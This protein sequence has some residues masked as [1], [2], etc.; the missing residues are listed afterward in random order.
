M[1]VGGIGAGFVS[2]D[3][4]GF[5][6]EG[7]VDGVLGEVDEERAVAGGFDEA[8]GVGG[9]PFGE[10]FAVGSVFEGRVAI[11]SEPFFGL[12]AVVAADVEGE[13]VG[14][15]GGVAEVPFADGGG[16][17]VLGFE[18]F[19]ESGEGFGEFLAPVGR[20]EFGGGALVAGDPVGDV[21]AGGALAGE[22]G[23]AG[24]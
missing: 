9:E 19:G 20:E 7:S 21:G 14:E 18:G 3:D 5:T 24:G 2:G 12:A 16:G 1:R 4:V 11:G 22:E 6:A 15:R 17:V 13:A 23:G 10:E 8:D